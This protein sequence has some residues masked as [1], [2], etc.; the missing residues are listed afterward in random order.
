MRQVKLTR[1]EREIEN[2]LLK[3]EY[4]DASRSNFEEI[5]QAL[6]HRKKDA[7]LNIRVNSKDLRGIK[8]KARKFGIKYQTFIS[9]IIHRAAHS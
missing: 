8:E 3:N 9:E 4:R 1:Q 2:A 6:A 7:V 5:A